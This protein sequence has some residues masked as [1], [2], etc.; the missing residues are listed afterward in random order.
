MATLN[1]EWKLY[2]YTL[3]FVAKALDQWPPVKAMFG[4]LVK[5]HKI[6]QSIG[7]HQRSSGAT[8]SGLSIASP[9]CS[10]SLLPGAG[11]HYGSSPRPHADH[12]IE[13]FWQPAGELWAG[14]R[15]IRAR[16]VGQEPLLQCA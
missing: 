12:F 3:V 13:Q 4:D 1:K 14:W 10:P 6:D 15:C 8:N 5:V 2:V 9:S 7:N 11:T 16:V